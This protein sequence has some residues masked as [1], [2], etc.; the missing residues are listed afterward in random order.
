MRLR[1]GQAAPVS[2]DP[3]AARRKSYKSSASDR[4]SHAAVHLRTSVPYNRVMAPTPSGREPC[5]PTPVRAGLTSCSTRTARAGLASCSQISAIALA[6]ALAACSRGAAQAARSGPPPAP[7]QLA[8]IHPVPIED[9]SVYLASVQSLSSTLI[10][11]QVAGDIVR[12]FV[13]SG[14]RVQAGTPLVQIDPRAQRAAV[15]SQDASRAAQEAMAAYARQQFERAKTLLAVGAISQQEFDQARANAEAAERQLSSLNARVQQE[16]VTL[17]YYEVRA[18]A[19]GIV[20]DV[21]VRVGTRVTTDS[22]LTS[23]D[24]NQLL[25]VYVQVPLDRS[26]DLKLGLPLQLSDGSTGARVGET[27]ISF[28]SPTVDEQTQSVLVKGRLAD[29]GTLRS[30]QFV[31]ARVVWK[32]TSGLVIPVLSVLRINGQPFVFV[33]END[34]GQLVARQRPIRLGEIIGNDYRVMD[35][36]Q[37]DERVVVSGVQRLINGAPIRPA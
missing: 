30:L 13:K 17:Q 18:P 28:I 14:D 9:A 29:G 32:T 23:V 3:M 33:A 11:P 7:V 16:Q 24:R 35:G 1:T 26:R 27:T 8:A 5:Q 21:P 20:G 36:L 6:L 4:L 10:K 15:S 22:V 12:I 34:K 25:E 2:L 19:A 37:P 31:R